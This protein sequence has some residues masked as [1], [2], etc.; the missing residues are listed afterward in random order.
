MHHFASLSRPRFQVL[1]CEN[2]WAQ[3]K[4][5]FTNPSS[6]RDTQICI[7]VKSEKLLMGV[8]PELRV[9]S[10][11]RKKSILAPVLTYFEIL[12][13]PKYAHTAIRNQNMLF[14]LQFWEWVATC[15]V[16]TLCFHFGNKSQHYGGV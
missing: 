3:I 5:C 9:L 13:S 10:V 8:K 6:E 11:C 2:D 7:H 4:L 15:H 14:W 1:G 12:N 16:M